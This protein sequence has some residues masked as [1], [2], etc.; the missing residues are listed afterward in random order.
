MFVDGASVGGGPYR[1]ALHGTIPE[2]GACDPRSGLFPCDPSL[3]CTQRTGSDSASCLVP[4]CSD[5]M[6][7]D[8]DGKTDYPN[9]PSCETARDDDESDPSPLPPCSDGLDNDQD[10]KTDYP[11]DPG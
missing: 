9:A 5:G 10:G 4:R 2:G 6:D 8:L 3:I 1:I 11:M 7:N